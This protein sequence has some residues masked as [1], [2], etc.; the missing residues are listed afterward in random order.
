MEYEIP[1]TDGFFYCQISFCRLTSIISLLY[2][3]YYCTLHSFCTLEYVGREVGF[4]VKSQVYTVCKVLEN[5]VVCR[6]IIQYIINI[7]TNSR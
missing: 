4:Y 2:D 3:C 7:I 6:R 5:S 1:S